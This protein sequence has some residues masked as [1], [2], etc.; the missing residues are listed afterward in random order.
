MELIFPCRQW[1]FW[2]TP[3]CAPKIWYEV[4]SFTSENHQEFF[5]D[6]RVQRRCVGFLKDT[7]FLLENLRRDLFILVHYLRRIVRVLL[8]IEHLAMTVMASELHES[9]APESRPPW[10]T[11]SG[12]FSSADGKR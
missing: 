4:L 7:T 8:D 12:N 5:R 9:P 2:R 3:S 11:L 6:A 10:I 1:L